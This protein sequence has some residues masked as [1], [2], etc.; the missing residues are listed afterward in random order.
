MDLRLVSTYR[1]VIYGFSIIY[2]VLF[3]G[4]AIDKGDYS[5]GFSALDWFQDF[6]SMGNIGVDIFL[7]LSGICLYFSFQKN[8]DSYAFIKKRLARVVP[9]AYIVYSLYWA[10]KYHFLS[11]NPMALLGRLTLMEFWIQGDTTIWFLSLILVLYFLYPYIYGFVFHGTRPELRCAVLML[12]SYLML[13]V[14]F[15]LAPGYFKMTEVALTRFPVFILG[16]Y[17][18]KFVYEGVRLPAFPFVPLAFVLF[19]FVYLVNTFSHLPGYVMHMVYLIGAVGGSYSLALV[20]LFFDRHAQLTVR[21]LYR[22]FDFTGG[23]TLELYFCSI[24]FNQ[25]LRMTPFY[26]QGNLGQY[27]ALMALSYVA[28]WLVGKASTAIANRL[29]GKTKSARSLHPGQHACP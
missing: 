7:L 5:F 29:L 2:I 18:G 12:A 13:F 3:H 15:N 26:D 10:V 28:A 17:M 4:I 8:D 6:I 19:L 25:V 9:S 23:I 27:L 11:F 1:G 24:M 16:C 14:L 21:P 22:F 20:C